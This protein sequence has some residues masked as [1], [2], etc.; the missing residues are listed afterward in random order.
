MS[1]Y[2]ISTSLQRGVIEVTRRSMNRFNGFSERPLKNGSE[3][4]LALGATRRKR[5][6]N[7]MTERYQ[8][9][10]PINI[11]RLAALQ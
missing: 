5:G 4:P 11:T 1:A 10:K 7:E 6:T 3:Y 9:P 8:M 2:I